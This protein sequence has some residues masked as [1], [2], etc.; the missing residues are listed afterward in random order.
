MGCKQAGELKQTKLFVTTGKP[1][2]TD[3]IIIQKTGQV[4]FDWAIEVS[5]PERCAVEGTL[6]H[7]EGDVAITFTAR[8]CDFKPQDQ[9]NHTVLLNGN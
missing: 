5:M 8:Q 3:V 9:E 7:D 4:C 6:S 2:V 1:F